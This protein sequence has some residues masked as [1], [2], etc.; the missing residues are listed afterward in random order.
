MTEADTL[1][2]LAYELELLLE[3]RIEA[4]WLDWYT[5]CYGS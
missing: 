3:E 5:R 2:W 1:R 4:V